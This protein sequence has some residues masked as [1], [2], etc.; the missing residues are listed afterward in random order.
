MFAHNA[1]KQKLSQCNDVRVNINEEPRSELTPLLDSPNKL[2]LTLTSI[3]ADV[4]RMILPYLTVEDV[5]NLRRSNGI[6]R[7]RINSALHDHHYSPTVDSLLS[8]LRIKK[9]AYLQSD[10]L[11]RKKCKF[12]FIEATLAEAACILAT[13]LPI[14]NFQA[15]YVTAYQKMVRLIVD[16]GSVTSTVANYYA[17]ECYIQSLVYNLPE[18]CIFNC[19]SN[20]ITDGPA[21][22]WFTAFFTA[23]TAY[24][25][26]RASLSTSY[27]TYPIRKIT[28]GLLALTLSGLTVTL[29][30]IANQ[31]WSAS[32]AI[33]SACC[34]ATECYNGDQIFPCDYLS[35][36]SYTESISSYCFQT[37]SGV[38]PMSAI[39]AAMPPL[40][41]T[42]VAFGAM[43]AVGFWAYRKNKEFCVA[44]QDVDALNEL[45][46]KY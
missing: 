40:A 5:N 2:S 34:F 42:G 30:V 43:A 28:M 29:P 18:N 32:S 36:G 35:P 23:N 31:G 37:I 39:L 22:Y 9:S 8:I 1:R 7:R 24:I 27:A 20:Q 25:T 41:L 19:A 17:N 4:W 16:T 13:S 33:R 10:K 38:V 6:V 12:Y 44:D 14:D 26:G 21:G 45:V 3:S 11:K 15:T 46:N